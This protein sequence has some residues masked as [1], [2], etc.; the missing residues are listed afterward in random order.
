MT[1][2][3]FRTILLSLIISIVYGGLCSLRAQQQPTTLTLQESLDFAYKNSKSIKMA[4]EEVK[5][6]EGKVNEALAAM[7]P[8]I[9]S[10]GSYTYYIKPLVTMDE[11]TIAQMQETFAVGTDAGIPTTQPATE[12]VSPTKIEADKHNLGASVSLQQPLFTWGRLTNSY[13][14]AKLNLEAARQGEE[15]TKQQLTFDVTNSFYGVLLAQEFVKVAED[16]VSQ[17]E[18][19]YKTANDLKNAGVATNYDVL[20]ASVQLANTRSQ[21]IK[22]Q[23]SLRLAKEGF[24]ITLGLPL[25]AEVNVEG[26]LA[27]KPIQRELEELMDL[28]LENRPDLKQLEL[29]EKA[30]EK[31][32]SIAKAGNKPNL[33]LFSSYEASK[34]GNR[35]DEMDWRGTKQS[36]S[37]GLALNIPIFDGLATRARVKQAKSGLNQL[38]LSKAQMMDGVQLDVKSAYLALQEAKALIDAQQETVQQ[39]Q[40]GLKIANSQYAN[41]IITS[42]ELN[43]AQ[44]A[45]TQ[46]EVNQ[47]QALFDHTIGLAKLEK[48]IGRSL[49]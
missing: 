44:L 23:N 31:L 37:V 49:E 28:A 11:E 13:K 4:Q 2:K 7:M 32:V 15:L 25:E 18:K 10:S 40:E 16:A 36:W 20:R 26:E 6:A 14:Q 48:A 46:A 39:A 1:N 17:V 38:E 33:G 19:H 34:S 42:V 35:E 8:N 29:Q 41:G 12:S 24:K 47:L 22:A 21:L 27:Y 43:D 5:L 30:G 45:L 3:R 9:S